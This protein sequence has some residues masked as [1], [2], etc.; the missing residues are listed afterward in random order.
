MWNWTKTK[1]KQL[2]EKKEYEALLAQISGQSNTAKDSIGNVIG[3][4]PNWTYQPTHTTHPF[5]ATKPGQ[6]IPLDDLNVLKEVYNLS[7]IPTNHLS[8]FE[9][10]EYFKWLDE[11]HTWAI[12]PDNNP[13]LEKYTQLMQQI[14]YSNMTNP[15]E[16][17]T[18]KLKLYHRHDDDCLYDSFQLN[19]RYHGAHSYI[20]KECHKP[21]PEEYTMLYVL[22]KT[23]KDTK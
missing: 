3:S 10:N 22:Q 19:E 14:S 2:D 1:T 7:N 4:Y 15:P 21:I 8:T 12:G 23:L 6:L 17:P 9:T 18:P 5:P 16:L 11:E 13:A 20:C